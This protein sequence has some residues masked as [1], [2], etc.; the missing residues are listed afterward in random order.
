MNTSAMYVALDVCNREQKITPTK[1]TRQL[2]LCTR[3]P[4]DALGPAYRATSSH[5]LRLWHR[6][7]RTTAKN[8]NSC[9][10]QTPPP[11]RCSPRR[12]QPT[13][14][15][16]LPKSS[17]LRSPLQPRTHPPARRS[18]AGTPSAPPPK[19]QPLHQPLPLRPRDADLAAAYCP[20][21]HRQVDK[22]VEQL[23]GEVEVPGR[24]EGG[25]GVGQGHPRDR[26]RR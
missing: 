25:G 24:G 17:P 6:H 12:L 16:T 15:L 13:P 26:R 11:P 20:A 7:R 14:A 22:G 1:T 23:R 2:L 10:L 8:R 18:L 19:S 5:T 9:T 21:D 4:F 3:A